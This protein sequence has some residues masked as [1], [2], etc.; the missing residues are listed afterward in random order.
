MDR[1]LIVFYLNFTKRIVGVNLIYDTIDESLSM[2]PMLSSHKATIHTT[3]M[4]V[5][6]RRT[7]TAIDDDEGDYAL[8]YLGKMAVEEKPAD[9]PGDMPVISWPDVVYQW[10]PLS[11]LPSWKMI[12]RANLP[13]E[14]MV[15]K[16]FYVDTA[17]MSDD[18]HAFWVDLMWGILFEDFY[19]TFYLKYI[20]VVYERVD[21]V[22]LKI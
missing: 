13:G 2:I 11:S 10:R 3:Q 16:W 14:W 17:F 18:G 9:K 4:L 12:K 8:T 15:D 20:L 6:R 19:G 21:L 1:N 5:T 22:L 7:T